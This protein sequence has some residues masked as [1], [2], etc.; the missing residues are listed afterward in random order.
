[1][2]AQ[3]NTQ[4]NLEEKWETIQ[5]NRS[6]ITSVINEFAKN[7]RG[8]AARQLSILANWFAKP[9]TFEQAL[10]RPDVLAICLPLSHSKTERE[11][12]FREPD[13]RAAV[14]SG[15][16]AIVHNSSVSQQLLQSLVYPFLMLLCAVLLAILFSSFVAPLFQEMF[17]EFGIALPVL[18]QWVLNSAA[19][20]RSWA[21]VFFFWLIAGASLFW[22][23]N[24]M[25]NK[26][27]Q[28]HMSWLDNNFQSTRDALAG[29]AWHLSL[30]LQSGVAQ[31]QA[32]WNAGFAAGKARIKQQSFR[33]SSV[34]E[35]ASDKAYF[36]VKFRLLDHA[37]TLPVSVGKIQLL[38]RIASYYRSRN[39]NMGQWWIGWL[40][41]MLYWLIGGIAFLSLMAIFMPM[42]SIVSGLTVNGIW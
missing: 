14:R 1:M 41:M 11:S 19:F 12:Q 22:L 4:T 31:P 16:S 38:Q 37:L 25:D 8:A 18:T 23:F 2:S 24:Y 5:T 27:R 17:E 33:L 42:F 10:K 3:L 15:F 26:R 30:L 20:L 21:W 29:W 32:I 35:V 39:R 9:R 36:G 7:E 13:V 28:S 40:V 6:V 34:K